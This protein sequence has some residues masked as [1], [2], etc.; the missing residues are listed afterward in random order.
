MR[1]GVNEEI[2]VPVEHP[3]RADTSPNNPAISWEPALCQA[4]S[5]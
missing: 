1:S 3:L 2:R 4:H 5:H